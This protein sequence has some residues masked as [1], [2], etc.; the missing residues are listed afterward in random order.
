MFSRCRH[1]SLAR[2]AHIFYVWWRYHTHIW[3]STIY[4]HIISCLQELVYKYIHKQVYVCMYARRT[5]TYVWVSFMIHFC[6]YSNEYACYKISLDILL[7]LCAKSWMIDAEQATFYYAIYLYTMLGAN[8]WIRWNYCVIIM[9][10]T[11]KLPGTVFCVICESFNT[12]KTVQ[13]I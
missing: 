12:I 10:P 7:W 11:T 13:S 8:Y 5:Y 4:I 1:S 3:Q 9:G 2:E 6:R